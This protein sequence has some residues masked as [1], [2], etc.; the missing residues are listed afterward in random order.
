MKNKFKKNIDLFSLLIMS[1]KEWAAQAGTYSRIILVVVVPMAVINILRTGKIS[2]DIGITAALIWTLVFTALLTYS[3]PRRSSADLKIG[4]IYTLAAARLLQYITVT[5]ALIASFLP[6]LVALYG[7][8]LGLTSLNISFLI[9]IPAAVSLGFFGL[10]LSS[11]LGVAQA[12]AVS[13]E[14]TAWESLRSSYR[15]TRGHRMIVFGGYFIIAIC[16]I[17]VVFLFSLVSI[18]S[19]SIYE[20][21]Y[22]QNI[23]YAST[24]TVFVPLVFIFQSKL[25]GALDAKK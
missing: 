14:K 13:S 1:M 20:N 16:I 18:L 22:L 8:I 6:A 23:F 25:L 2:L 12:I 19:Q 24:I 9:L 3:L 11:S 4:A 7:L 5:I 10:V 15:L 21:V 17:L